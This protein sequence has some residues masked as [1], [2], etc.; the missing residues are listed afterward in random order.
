[1]QLQLK[2]INKDCHT[3]NSCSIQAHHV[4][5]PFSQIVI[6]KEF[7]QI[8][9]KENAPVQCTFLFELSFFSAAAL[10]FFSCQPWNKKNVDFSKFQFLNGVL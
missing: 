9:P 1:M 8:P 2:Y 10:F 3:K 7:L 4:S 5:V 6:C